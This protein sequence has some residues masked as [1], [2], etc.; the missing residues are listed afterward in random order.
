MANWKIEIMKIFKSIGYNK[1]KFII[2]V[3][4]F[5]QVHL[6]NSQLKWNT[7]CLQSKDPWKSEWVRHFK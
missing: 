4:I 5:Y 7:R 6:R 2:L 3:I 1:K